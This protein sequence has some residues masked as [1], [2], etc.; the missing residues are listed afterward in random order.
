MQTDVVEK[1]VQ[2]VRAAGERVTPGRRA[3]LEVLAEAH[4]HLDA[5]AIAERVN[6]LV[7]GVHRA[8]VYRSLSSLTDIGV[9]THTH[10]PGASTIYHL[11]SSDQHPPHGHLQCTG[12]GRFVDLPLDAME[13]LAEKV[14]ADSGFVIETEHAALLGT[15]RSCAD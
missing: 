12:C 3:V 10:V 13:D 8:T 5:D 15:C 4:R 6:D 1:A 11:A 7:P 14:R 2:A 9:V